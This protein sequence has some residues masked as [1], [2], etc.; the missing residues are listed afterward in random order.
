[1]SP[2]QQMFA[3]PRA[4]PTSMDFEQATPTTVVRVNQ[5]ATPYGATSTDSGL[6]WTAFASVPSGM[7]MGGG[8]IAVAP[9]GSSIVWAPT[10]T[11][12]VWYSKNGG[13]SWT[14]STGIA[15]Q[16][17]VV[18]DRV[19]A[20]VFYGLS[21]TT[22]TI[23]TDGGATFITVQT[24]LPANSILTVLPDVQGDLW[25]SGQTAGLYTN[26]GTAA[27][28][29]LTAVSGVA[30]A[31]HLGFGMGANGGA[32]P[33]LYLDGQVGTAPGIYRSTDGGATWMQINDAAHQYGQL[34][35]ICGDMRTFGT[36]YL[37]TAGRGIIWGTTFN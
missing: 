20:G 4:T 12:S 25:L 3:A 26:T 30:D 16:A 24:A 18:S 7:T 17:Q 1:M 21:G 19:K 14:A 34:N 10:D 22:L 9:D 32:K 15:A 27:A 2:P 6:N 23:S 35:G 11:T 28:P 29:N 8:N 36:V 31:Y 37:A 13:T 5:T 33:A